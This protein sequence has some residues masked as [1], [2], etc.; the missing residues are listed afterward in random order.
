MSFYKGDLVESGATAARRRGIW[1]K[2]GVEAAQ[3]EDKKGPSPIVGLARRTNE[4]SGNKPW[5]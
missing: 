4:S 3:A 1:D 2:P 5:V